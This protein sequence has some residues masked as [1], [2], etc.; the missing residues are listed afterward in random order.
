MNKKTV[1]ILFSIL[2][3]LI[4][5]KN[6]VKPEKTAWNYTMI[7]IGVVLLGSQMYRF[8]SDNSNK[9]GA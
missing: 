3:V 6:A 8:F 4:I 9:N 1:D 5:A 7:V 2:T